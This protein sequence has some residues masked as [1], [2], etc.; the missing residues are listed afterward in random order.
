MA[1]GKVKGVEALLRW[2]DDQGLIQ[3]PG[4][5][6]Q[7][8][9]ELGLIN[10]ITFDVLDQTIKS[11]D[12]IEE[13][14]GRDVTVSLNVAA[15]QACDIAFMTSLVEAVAAT[16]KPN[17]FML[18]LTEEAFFATQRFQTD[19]LPL[20]RAVGARVSIDDFGVGYSSLAALA[21]IT[22]DE[23]K[24]DRTFIT[25]IHKRPRSQ[26]VLKAIE[27]LGRALG[28]SIIA[29]GV[30][31]AE[32]VAYLQSSTQIQHAQGFYFGRP[33]LIDGVWIGHLTTSHGLD[34]LAM[35]HPAAR[36]TTALR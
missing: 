12:A 28:M 7:L 34:G 3:A 6:I 29:E 13:I 24:I 21:D 8:A 33:M 15:K 23:L 22:A 14:Y 1:T 26:V 11:M 36:R 32:E 5:F 10:D 9:V 18:E 25:D 30:E 27:S 35:R 19:V 4:E 2:Q 20:I 31:S 16:G 17:R